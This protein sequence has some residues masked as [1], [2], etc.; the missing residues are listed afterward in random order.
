MTDA[1]RGG[2][3]NRA[4]WAL[5]GVA[6]VIRAAVAYGACCLTMALVWQ[7]THHGIGILRSGAAWAGATLL[8]LSA[9]GT[10]RSAWRLRR[11]LRA[12]RAV[13]REVRERAVSPAVENLALSD[14]AVDACMAGRVTVIEAAAPFAFTYG[15]LRPRV[16]V[17]SGMV[18]AAARGELSA[19]L[20]HECAHVRGRDPLKALAAATLTA[21]HFGF[22]LLG[23]LRAVHTAD[24]ELAADRH[25]VARYGTA[26]VAGA[27]LKATD[28]P[29]WAAAAPAAAMGAQ[30][31]LEAR[32]TQLEKGRPPRPV[33]PTCRR[34]ASS[35]AGVAAY[36]WVLAG[37][38][39][40]IAATPL[41]CVG[42]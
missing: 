9:A 35:A 23:Q 33:R 24:R 38:A 29:R 41:A 13:A 28:V 31:L 36:A 32:I 42:K 25:A 17:S 1:A 7:A 27:L 18:A 10:A 8:A 3:G 22:P 39:T 34:V 15:L 37:S 14:A 30:D 6:T 26:A 40:L 12:T 20:A 11:G 5:I 21:R 4:F 2:A 16:A 19:V